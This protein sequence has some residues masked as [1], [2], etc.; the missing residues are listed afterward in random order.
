MP[1]AELR[2]PG[3]TAQ[4]ATAA[5]V[6]SAPS[7]VTSITKDAGATVSFLAPVSSGSGA[8]TQ[9][10]VTPYIA[11]TAQAPTV[12][13][14]GSVGTITGSNG[15]T[16]LQ[17]PAAGLA[18]GTA[19]TF[20]VH[21]VNAYGSGPESAQSGANT[22]LAGLVFGDDF[23]GPSGG[24]IDPEWW[25]YNRCGYIAQSEVEW[26]LPSQVSLDGSSHLVLTA[27]HTSHAGPS[28]PS[29]GNTSRTQPWL[30]GSVQSNT[31]TYNPSTGNTLTVAWSFKTCADA[32]NGFW[33][34][35]WLEGSTYL[36]AWKT[37]P[38]QSGWNST[39]QAEI[40][41]AEWT[42]GQAS[43]TQY[44]Q[45]SWT[46]GS[47]YTAS[48]TPGGAFDSSAAFH[49]YSVQW[50]PGT[51]V[52]FYLDGSLTNTASSNIPANGANFFLMLYLQMLAGGP[53]TTE[54]CYADYVRV[55]DLP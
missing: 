45:S 3:R 24:P 55:F 36:N 21:A 54:S 31:R 15:N 33:P 19:Y 44:T 27:T 47:Q 43:T 53:T 4:A 13:A 52:K 11:G 9:Y 12:T 30:S 41:I 50:K 6:P 14:V 18:N 29:D 8:I 51:S 46:S 23:N 49:E 42:P 10:V 48:V 37:D 40:D 1:R 22:P 34:S 2:W 35:P 5:G 16:Y 26:Y 20:T 32:A 7:S 17:A 38:L 39:G 28:Y 25:V